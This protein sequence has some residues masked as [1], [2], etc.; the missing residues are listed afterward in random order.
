M[1]EICEDKIVHIWSSAH[2]KLSRA[3]LSFVD[4]RML[5]ELPPIDL[6]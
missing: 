2:I 6:F 3:D 4:I 1:L 5:S